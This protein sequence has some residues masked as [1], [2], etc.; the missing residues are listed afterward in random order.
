VDPETLNRM[1]EK[2]GDSWKFEDFPQKVSSNPT[3]TVYGDEVINSERSM[4]YQK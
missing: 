3:Q 1:M 4:H 2:D